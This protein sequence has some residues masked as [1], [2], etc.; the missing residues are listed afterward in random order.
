L[1]LVAAGLLVGIPLTFALSSLV[2]SQLFGLEPHDPLTL[3]SAIVGLTFVAC[4]AGLL[5]AL[6][7]SRI[8]PLQSLRDE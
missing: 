7:A 1:I 3:T 2:R 8:D 4:L 5:P 6:K